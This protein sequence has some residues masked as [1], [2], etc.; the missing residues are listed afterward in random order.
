MERVLPAAARPF[1]DF[2]LV[3]RAH[4]FTAATDQ[5]VAFLKAIAVLGPRSMRDVYWAARTTLAP[6]PDRAAEFDGLFEAFFRG[7]AGL[8]AIA[9]S[10]P[11]EDA[12]A[13]ESGAANL[14]PAVADKANESGEAASAAEALTAKSFKAMAPSDRLALMRP[15]A[16]GGGSDPARLPAA[17][18]PARRPARP[19]PQPRGD[20]PPRSRRRP[21]GM[22]ATAGNPAP[23][24][25]PPRH[26]RL[27]EA[28][29]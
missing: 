8:G 17:A 25:P 26:L 4:G 22:D 24:S 21:A 13:R 3:L 2:T 15:P 9:E 6:P 10:M 23:R 14:D 16:R 11:E 18:L 12:P 29:D 5:T 7:E 28:R 20:G 19:P 1:H 27:D